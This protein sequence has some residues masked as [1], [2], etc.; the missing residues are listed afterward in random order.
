MRGVCLATRSEI[1]HR[2]MSA[3]GSSAKAL[4]D[5]FQSLRQLHGVAGV[6]LPDDVYVPPELRELSH[7]TAVTLTIGNELS[8][9]EGSSLIRN[10][11][12]L[13]ACVMMPETSVDQYDCAEAGKH[14]VWMAWKL[15]RMQPEA[16]AHPMHCGPHDKFWLGVAAPN[17]CHHCTALG[18]A[19]D[20]SHVQLSPST[21][22]TDEAI[23][24]ARCGG[25]AFPTC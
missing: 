24:R 2:T 18:R 12:Q 7:V 21:A 23:C 9:P 4:Y 13:A 20:V 1:R 17:A 16:V 10:V 25:T 19:Q 22:A 8:C 3:Y 15:P 11:R 14:Y 5:G 6:A